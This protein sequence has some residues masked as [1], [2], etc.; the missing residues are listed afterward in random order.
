LLPPLLLA[1]SHA[2]PPARPALRKTFSA[3]MTG[4]SFAPGTGNMTSNNQPI[5]I[6][7]ALLS[8]LNV[9]INPDGRPVNVVFDYH[10][11]SRAG[12]FSLQP[13]FDEHVCFIFPPEYV[14]P[15]YNAFDIGVEFL[16]FNQA[17]D[18]NV[19]DYY[20]A[21]KF[22]GTDQIAGQA[23]DRWVYSVDECTQYE[24]D[25]TSWC[26][27][28]ANGALYSV[29]RSVVT[30]VNTSKGEQLY[31][32]QLRNTFTDYKPSA[33]PSSF[34]VPSKGC[35]DMRPIRSSA[36]ESS[37]ATSSYDSDAN[38]ASR[39][40]NDQDRIAAINAAAAGGWHAAPSAAWE[41]VR[42]DDDVSR[43]GLLPVSHSAGRVSYR[44]QGAAGDPPTEVT[45]I[46]T[47]SK[48]AVHP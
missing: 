19:M 34:A 32:Q 45:H 47:P 48:L 15:Q 12:I 10:N 44:E 5:A 21:S 28:R 24:C 36:G 31:N 33:E 6:S 4:Y 11:D 30:K 8:I 25:Q 23:C 39:L 37:D 35:A 20:A 16:W 1:L 40:L 9:E 17:W 14:P 38:G 18:K 46:A 2:D 27:D 13:F 22:N 3:N 29:N 42:A 41:G 7:E 26:V 43:L